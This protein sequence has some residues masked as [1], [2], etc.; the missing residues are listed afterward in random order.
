M[1]W[2]AEHLQSLALSE[3]HE[4]YLLGRGAQEGTIA[5][6]GIKTWHPT[7]SPVP[8]EAF[9]AS[10]GPHGEAWEGWLMW[11]LLCPRGRVLGVSGRRAPYKD[12][13]RHLLPEADWHPVFVGLTP[14]AMSRIWDGTDIWVV[15]GI[16]D[17]FPLEWARP[18]DVVLGTERAHMA[19]QHIDFMTRFA[20]RPGQRVWL[21]YDN[22]VAGQK[23]MHGGVNAQGQKRL[24]ALQRLQRAGVAA[25]PFAYSGKDPGA[26]W[27]HGGAEKVR[28]VFGR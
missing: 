27:E 14:D 5:R 25:A 11:P 18:H 15:E 28:L 26:V 24:G 13:S 23:A 12:I 19:S 10:F 21:V 6:L 9:R 3:E 20:R 2:L 22:D 16:F 17:L 1:T 7:Q 8:D 4:G